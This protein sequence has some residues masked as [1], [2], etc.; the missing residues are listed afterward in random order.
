MTS[1][2]NER[3]GGMRSEPRGLDSIRRSDY[4]ITNTVRVSSPQEVLRAVEQLLVSGWPRLT[5]RSV[6]RAFGD[7]DTLFAGRMPGYAG[8][9]T[10]YH[11]RQ[12]TLDV[13]LAMAR[14][15]AGYE[16]Q[17]EAASGRSARCS[18]SC[19]HCFTMSATCAAAPITRRPTAPNSR[20]AT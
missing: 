12:H 16:R 19:W 5:L 13:T 1:L 9:D 17:A 8:V 11:D 2:P 7:F 15:L 18:A 14:L 20:A 6:E 3:S 10:V 4:D